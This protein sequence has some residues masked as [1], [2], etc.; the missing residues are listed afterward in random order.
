MHY[1]DNMVYLTRKWSSDTV[2]RNH[3]AVCN[4]FICAISIW[5][6]IEKSW[7]WCGS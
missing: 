1:E 6:S 2:L 3:D 4:D 7:A 5:L